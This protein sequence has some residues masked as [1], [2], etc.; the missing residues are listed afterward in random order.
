ME[1]KWKIFHGDNCPN[2][3]DALEVFSE[4]PEEEDTVFETLVYDGEP[5][6]CMAE[7]GFESC[8]EVT[9]DGNAYVQEGNIEELEG[10]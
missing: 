1:K 8:T 6:R 10:N 4:C 2:C 3:G 9:E 7:C 5:V